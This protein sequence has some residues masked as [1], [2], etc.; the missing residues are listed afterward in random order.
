MNREMR[1]R[2]LVPIICPEISFNYPREILSELDFS[3]SV[4]EILSHSS[5]SCRIVFALAA[6]CRCGRWRCGLD[7]NFRPS[8]AFY[9]LAEDFWIKILFRGKLIN[10]LIE[11]DDGVG[12]VGVVGQ[13]CRQVFSWISSFCETFKAILYRSG[14]SKIQKSTISRMKVKISDAP[15]KPLQHRANCQ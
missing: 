6:V 14:L 3:H 13:W 12:A 9:G 8:F 4:N 10:L 11:V 5:V 1:E 7:C 2:F 15:L